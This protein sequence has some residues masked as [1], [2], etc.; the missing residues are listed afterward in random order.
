[1]REFFFKAEN[2]SNGD[3]WTESFLSD[4]YNAMVDEREALRELQT[5]FSTQFNVCNKM[6]DEAEEAQKRA[7]EETYAI[8]SANER[9]RETVKVK[10]IEVL[11]VIGKQTNPNSVES[12]R[13][14]KLVM[15]SFKSGDVGAMLER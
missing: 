13:A 9:L 10:A 7:E 15:S 11:K 12:Q 2:E 4:R 3:A 14:V 8:R 1:L 5:S 6:M